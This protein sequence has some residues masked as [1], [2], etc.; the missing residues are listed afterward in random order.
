MS[1][2]FIII[3]IRTKHYKH[4]GSQRNNNTRCAIQTSLIK[5]SIQHIS[6][7]ETRLTL[8]HSGKNDGKNK[9]D[10]GVFRIK[11][12]FILGYVLYRYYQ[13]KTL[14]CAR[15]DLYQVTLRQNFLLMGS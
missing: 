12:C 3:Y 1:D 5:D 14:V 6:M 7:N 4:Y 13:S 10:L 8:E 15:Y 2:L 9:S 11:T